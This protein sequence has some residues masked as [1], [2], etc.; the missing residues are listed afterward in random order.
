MTAKELAYKIISDIE[1][2]TERLSHDELIVVYEMLVDEYEGK[3]DYLEG[4]DNEN[5]EAEDE[6]T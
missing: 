6:L 5:F 1:I 2:A 3:L 4:L